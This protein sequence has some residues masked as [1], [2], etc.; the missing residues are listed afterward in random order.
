MGIGE[1][2]RNQKVK[3]M[4]GPKFNTDTTTEGGMNKVQASQ[5]KWGL[6]LVGTNLGEK[7]YL[8]YPV[9]RVI[10]TNNQTF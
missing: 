8:G 10:S 2:P 3:K 6:S 4:L 9:M 1:W 7:H 5:R